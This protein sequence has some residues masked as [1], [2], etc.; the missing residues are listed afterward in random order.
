MNIIINTTPTPGYH[1]P[2]EIQSVVIGDSLTVAEVVPIA[3]MIAVMMEVLLI[4]V[5]SELVMGV[6][7]LLVLMILVVAA[8]RVLV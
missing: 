3:A 2:C 8:V 6:A 7:V 5:L 1:T 4:V